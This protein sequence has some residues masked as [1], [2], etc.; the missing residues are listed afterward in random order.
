RARG[1]RVDRSPEQDAGM[2][3][4]RVDQHGRELSLLPG[5]ISRH[6]PDV[7]RAYADRAA[8]VQAVRTAPGRGALHPALDD[9]VR[10]YP[11]ESRRRARTESGAEGHREESQR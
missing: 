10:A 9:A 3:G 11:E 5:A 7:Y 1:S 6:R 4:S 8:A 2:E